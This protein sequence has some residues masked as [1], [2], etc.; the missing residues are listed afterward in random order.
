MSSITS[1]G[2]ESHRRPSRESNDSRIATRL[3]HTG[4]LTLVAATYNVRQRAA[5]TFDARTEL[6]PDKRSALPA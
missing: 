5:G 1:R 4:T 3:L 2:N 6:L